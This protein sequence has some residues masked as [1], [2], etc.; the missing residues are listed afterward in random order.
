MHPQ[1]AAVDSLAALLRAGRSQALI[2][3]DFDGTVAPI[4]TDPAQARPL[5]GMAD[6]L[7]ALAEQGAHIALISGRDV[8]TLLELS[9][10]AHL[11]RLTAIGLYGAESWHAGQFSEPAEPPQLDQLRTGLPQLV[12]KG[13]TGLRIEDKGLSLVVHA[14]GTSQPGPALAAIR[15]AVAALA[16]SLGMEVHPGRDVLEIRLPGFDK[17]SALRGLVAASSPEL[18]LFA[19]DDAGDLP[20]FEAIAEFRAAGRPAWSV[21]VTS[22]EVPGLGDHADVVVDGPAGLLDLLLD[23]SRADNQ[24]S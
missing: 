23:I 6:A 17:G 15:P 22:A 21:A 19:G 8:R 1:A 3:L 10:L 9:G 2:A 12:A 14:R 13:A 20:A 11:P 24:E 18:V 5:D 7:S 4:V 16:R